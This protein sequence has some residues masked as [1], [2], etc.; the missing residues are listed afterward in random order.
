MQFRHLIFVPQIKKSFM[1]IFTT[2]GSKLNIYYKL[3]GIY[4]VNKLI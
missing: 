3:I 1:L 4:M 2:V